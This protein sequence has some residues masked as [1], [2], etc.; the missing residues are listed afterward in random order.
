MS[1]TVSI[2]FFLLFP[3][4]YEDS[5]S[6]RDHHRR[7]SSITEPHGKETCHCNKPEQQP[8]K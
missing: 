7:G 6:D 5:V 3:H 8:V 1:L 2:I 4:F